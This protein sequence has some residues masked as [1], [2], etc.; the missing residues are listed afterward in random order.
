ME[1][2]TIQNSTQRQRIVPDIG[3]CRLAQTGK[4]IMHRA[5]HTRKPDIALPYDTP[6]GILLNLCR[7]VQQRTG[8]ATELSRDLTNS[9]ECV[10]IH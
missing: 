2:E 4:H 6:E 3:G 5:Y 10:I 8:D 7:N 9:S 1:P